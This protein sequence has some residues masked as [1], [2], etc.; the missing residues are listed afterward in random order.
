MGLVLGLGLYTFIYAKGYSY[1]SDNPE[2]CA[3]C[4][5][6]RGHLDG[7]AKSSHR[8]AATCNDCHT[9]AAAVGKYTVKATNGFFHSLAFT[10]GRFADNIQIKP[11]NHRV[12]ELACRHCHGEIVAEIEGAHREAASVSCV[13]CHLSVGHATEVAQIHPKG[14]FE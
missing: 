13:R 11:R 14:S 1:L 9:P 8:A 2:A 10:S 5:V 7:W 12:T 6:M 4:H 3:N